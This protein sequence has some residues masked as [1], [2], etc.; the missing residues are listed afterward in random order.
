MYE[1][2]SDSYNPVN[3]FAGDYPV[4]KDYGKVKENEVIR[5]LVPVVSSEAGFEEVTAENI[6]GLYGIAADDSS[7][8]EVVM[9]LTGEFFTEGIT[10]PEGV[11]ANLLKPAFRKLGIFLK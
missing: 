9:Y 3:V 6:S 1:I 5:K 11:T 8:G 2:K 10:M 7:G 4:I